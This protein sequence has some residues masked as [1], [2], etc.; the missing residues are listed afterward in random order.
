MKKVLLSA[1]LVLVATSAFAGITNSKHDFSA[2]GSSSAYGN[3][4]TAGTQ[5][6]VYCHT[7]HNAKTSAL[8]WN[9][10]NG[11]AVT[12]YNKAVSGTLNFDAITGI[13]ATSTL[14]L[15]CHDGTVAVDSF[16]SNAG[17]AATKLTGAANLG[18]TLTDDH[19]IGF[20]YGTQ[21]DTDIV[22]AGGTTPLP[23]FVNGALIDSMECATCHDVHGKNNVAKFLRIDNAGSNL[24]I[25]CHTK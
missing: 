21:S 4:A 23:L 17:N 7:P 18:A 15:S 25:N 2:T 20:S 13:G 19:P 11:G 12:V 8:L 6:C 22:A 1:A 24:C 3:A 16:A 9:R 10:N 14:C 5:I